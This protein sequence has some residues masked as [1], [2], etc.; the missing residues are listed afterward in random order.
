M[1]VIMLRHVTFVKVTISRQPNRK[2]SRVGMGSTSQV[3][4]WQLKSLSIFLQ[5]RNGLGY[6]AK[7]NLELEVCLANPHMIATP[8]CKI[9]LDICLDNPQWLPL[10]GCS[11]EGLPLQVCLDFPKL[12]T[13]PAC[14]GVVSKKQPTFSFVSSLFENCT[15]LG[16]QSS[17]PTPP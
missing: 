12:L 17:F 16:L 15:F 10:V 6:N 8:K 13:S 7:D 1:L 2:P 9:P 3:K 4:C 5:T 11:G 14:K